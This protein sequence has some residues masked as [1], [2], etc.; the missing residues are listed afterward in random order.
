MSNHTVEGLKELARVILNVSTFLTTGYVI[1][2]SCSFLYHEFLL[3]EGVVPVSGVRHLG[4]DDIIIVIMGLF[5]IIVSFLI[6]KRVNN[7]K[8]WTRLEVNH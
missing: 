3:R 4:I 6:T 8:L 1:M 2:L 7:S 5:S